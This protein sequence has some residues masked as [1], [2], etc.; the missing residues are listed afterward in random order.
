[1]G[2]CGVWEPGRPSVVLLETAGS[3][4]DPP[5]RPEDLSR[6]HLHRAFL[7][8]SYHHNH[9]RHIFIFLTRK[10]VGLSLSHSIGVF[11][12]GRKVYVVDRSRSS[13]TTTINF[14]VARQVP[15][16]TP[17]RQNLGTSDKNCHYYP[18]S[19]RTIFLVIQHILY[20]DVWFI[21]K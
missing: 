19:T 12:C 4:K 5:S 17:T 3:L 21:K 2:P 15:D 14:V 11:L 6:S 18:P 7:S 8:S 20:T 16:S 10:F 1:M 13:L 9:H